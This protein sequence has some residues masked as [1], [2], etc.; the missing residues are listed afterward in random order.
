MEQIEKTVYRD[1]AIDTWLDTHLTRIQQEEANDAVHVAGQKLPAL[2]GDSFTNYFGFSKFQALIDSVREKLPADSILFDVQQTKAAA[3]Q[4]K[5]NLNNTIKDVKDALA[6]CQEPPAK[7]AHKNQ[8]ALWIYPAIL[9]IAL[10][11]GFFSKPIFDA[12]G[13]SNRSATLCSFLLAGI[14]AV[15]FH[16]AVHIMARGKTNT[17]RLARAVLIISTVLVFFTVVGIQRAEYL[18][19]LAQENGEDIE[20]SPWLFTIVSVA[21][22]LFAIALPTFLPSEKEKA[23][24]AHYAA[25]HTEK[26]TLEQELAAAQKRLKDL[27]AETAAKMLAA[28][29]QYEYGHS[30]E[31]KI[32]ATAEITYNAYKKINISRRTDGV[33]DCFRQPYSH[34]FT[35][36]FNYKTNE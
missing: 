19:A 3:E 14:L 1:I 26:S 33:P 27:D 29:A 12:A 17:A 32:I 2:T 23:D 7:P 5:T 11:E 35:T 6:L 10:L 30:L 34:T 31:K 21:L 22:S 36:N 8:N 15:F 13:L 18:T 16:S 25:W 24:Y 4:E 28:A 9:C 20:Y